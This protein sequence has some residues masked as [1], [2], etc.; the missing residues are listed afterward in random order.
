MSGE[1]GNDGPRNDGPRQVFVT[2]IGHL[3]ISSKDSRDEVFHP[4]L[5]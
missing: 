1:W 4:A 2:E 5:E 3:G